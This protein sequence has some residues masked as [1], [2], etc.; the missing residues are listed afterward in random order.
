[1]YWLGSRVRWL[2]HISSNATRADR[3]RDYM[4]PNYQLCVTKKTAEYALRPSFSWCS[5]RMTKFNAALEVPYAMLF[6]D[7]PSDIEPMLPANEEIAMN[8]GDDVVAFRSGYTAWNKTSGPNVFTCRS[9]S[10]TSAGE[11]VHSRRSDR[12]WPLVGC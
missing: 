5:L 2:T 11:P 12:A 6:T 4:C 1:V 7:I 9:I 10:I 3:E 8:F